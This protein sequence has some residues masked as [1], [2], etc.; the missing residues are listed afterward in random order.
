MLIMSASTPAPP[1]PFRSLEPTPIQGADDYLT[2]LQKP[3]FTGE[4]GSSLEPAR[5]PPAAHPA[6][7]DRQQQQLQHLSTTWRQSEATITSDPRPST[8]LP[9][10][11]HTGHSDHS[12]HSNHSNRS[13]HSN[14]SDPSQ[15]CLPPKPDPPAP[16]PTHYSLAELASDVP[17]SPPR[18]HGFALDTCLQPDPPVDPPEHNS[19]AWTTAFII[20]TCSTQYLAQGQFGAVI[21]PLPEIGEW[22]GTE[23]AGELSWMAA[24]YG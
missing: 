17:D 13:T 23:D 8:S 4:G 19:W 2:A 1:G 24:S 20:V 12:N 5:P 18:L 16:S 22:L 7:P 14:H 9:L 21:I 10:L 6:F 11:P 3:S 15:P